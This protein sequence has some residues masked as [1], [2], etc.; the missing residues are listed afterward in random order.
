M[1]TKNYNY[2]PA[3]QLPVTQTRLALPAAGNQSLY[4]KALPA[5]SEMHQLN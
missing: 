5:H 3:P 4:P 1:K 2:P